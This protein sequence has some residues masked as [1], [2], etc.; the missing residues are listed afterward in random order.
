MGESRLT[1]VVDWDMLSDDGGQ[2]Q[3]MKEY[4]YC[5]CSDALNVI[6][7]FYVPWT[8]ASQMAKSKIH[9]VGS[10]SAVREETNIYKQM[11]LS[12]TGK[13]G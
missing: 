11:I 5:F 13:E 1:V 3:T 2:S 12:M 7:C 4:I 8:K 10:N 6:P 9:G